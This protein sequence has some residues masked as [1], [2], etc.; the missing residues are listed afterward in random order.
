MD[1]CLYVLPTRLLCV[2]AAKGVTVRLDLGLDAHKLLIVF[3]G[4][5]V[6]ISWED[7]AMQYNRSPAA[8][9]VIV[10][11]LTSQCSKRSLDLST[12]PPLL[13]FPRTYMRYVSVPFLLVAIVLH[14]VFAFLSTLR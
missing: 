5:S 4:M 9:L 3:I 1:G 12:V 13:T 11:I 6:D 10:D 14:A 7:R 2:S 8:A